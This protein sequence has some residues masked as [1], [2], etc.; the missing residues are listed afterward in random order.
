MESSQSQVITTDIKGP[1]GIYFL[2]TVGKNGEKSVIKVLK[3][4]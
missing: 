1:A 2:T 3:K 4:N